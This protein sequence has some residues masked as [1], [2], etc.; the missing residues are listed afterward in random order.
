MCW[1]AVPWFQE[2]G[3]IIGSFVQ[4]LNEVQPFDRF[5]IFCLPPTYVTYPFHSSMSYTAS[6]LLGT[7]SIFTMVHPQCPR[8]N[9]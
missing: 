3:S 9:D 5:D 4:T 7:Y 1:P 6:N 2:L 8:P